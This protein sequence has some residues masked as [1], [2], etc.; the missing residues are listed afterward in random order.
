MCLVEGADGPEGLLPVGACGS[1]TL[2]SK[3]RPHHTTK[4]ATVAAQ[5]INERCVSVN[6]LVLKRLRPQWIIAV[7]RGIELLVEDSRRVV[8]EVIAGRLFSVGFLCL[9]A[10]QLLPSFSVVVRVDAYFHDVFLHKHSRV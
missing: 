1:A 4:E 5:V 7:G 6:A 10:R 2:A 8:A 9:A 3:E